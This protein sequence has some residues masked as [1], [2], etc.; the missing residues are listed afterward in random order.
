ML[1]AGSRS[2]SSRRAA[3]SGSRPM[4][5]RSRGATSLRRR[6]DPESRH[7]SQRPGDLAVEHRVARHDSLFGARSCRAGRWLPAAR[8]RWSPIV[9]LL[10]RSLG[11]RPRTALLTTPPGMARK[12]KRR[13]KAFAVLRT[14]SAPDL[15][16]RVAISAAQGERQLQVGGTR[17]RCRPPDSGERPIPR[18]RSCRTGTGRPPRDTGPR[19]YWARGAGPAT[20]CPP[21]SSLAPPRKPSTCSPLSRA[22]VRVWARKR[23]R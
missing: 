15:E 6:F 5:K 14:H 7:Q 2:A 18:R 22:L 20:G 8:T 11:S 4:S 16:L 10:K 12:R 17:C 19:G 23:R 1:R 3:S 13:V 9:S 21:Q